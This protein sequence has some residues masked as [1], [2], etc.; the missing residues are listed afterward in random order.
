[1]LR[2]LI[3][4][5]VVLNFQLA[6]MAENPTTWKTFE[7]PEGGF[8]ISL[9][10]APIRLKKAYPEQQVVGFAC[11]SKE[12]DCNFTVSYGE[13][14]QL[15]EGQTNE[16]YFE[17]IVADNSVQGMSKL[18][19]KRIFTYKDKYSALEATTS[20]HVKTKD[21]KEVIE[22]WLVV[23]TSKHLIGVRITGPKASI[24]DKQIAEC[25]SS[26]KI[27]E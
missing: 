4:L 8:S 2:I 12:L 22:K 16:K 25:L 9:P 13:P 10:T 18:A 27:K 1:M 21:G 17:E 11:D 15:E 23:V 24:E 20:P 3:S 26:L 5:L 7:S 19:D 14:P 6:A